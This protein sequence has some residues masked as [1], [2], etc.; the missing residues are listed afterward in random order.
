MKS[1]IAAASMVLCAPVASAGSLLD[2]ASSRSSYSRGEAELA[3]HVPLEAD[4]ITRPDELLVTVDVR[5]ET[6]DP[7]RA[8]YTASIAAGEVHKRF[9][10]AGL[11]G[12]LEFQTTS[13]V[14][15][16]SRKMSGDAAEPVLTSVGFLLRLPLPDG[17]FW[18]RAQLVA[19][20]KHLADELTRDSEGAKDGYKLRFAAPVPHVRNAEKFREELLKQ[21]GA[22]IREVS[23]LVSDKAHPLV[24]S[25]CSIP[26]HVVQSSASLEQSALSLQLSCILQAVR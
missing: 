8:V 14:P 24:P 16:E 10:A 2:A 19:K 9:I 12:D 18:S 6:P 26:G 13:S 23:L 21:I 5:V 7:S 11:K 15:G 3:A 20:A 17:D 22:R 4:L 25:E 1:L